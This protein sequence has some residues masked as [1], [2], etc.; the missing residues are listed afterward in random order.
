MRRG[1][2]FLS[3]ARMVVHSVDKLGGGINSWSKF[4]FDVFSRSEIRLLV[5]SRGEA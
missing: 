2:M 5:D 4:F 3:K 1:V